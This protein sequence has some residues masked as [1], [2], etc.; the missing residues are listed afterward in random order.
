MKNINSCYSG[1]KQRRSNNRKREAS[2]MSI[3][4]RK[5]IEDWIA[6]NFFYAN[7][8]EDSAIDVEAVRAKL[9]EMQKE[10]DMWKNPWFLEQK[11]DR[12]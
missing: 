4:E 1:R 11:G 7:D 10:I 3:T 6:S 9:L 12:K 2:G 8:I 5:G